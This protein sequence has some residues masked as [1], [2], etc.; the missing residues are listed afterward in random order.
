MKTT[1]N[2]QD[3]WYFASSAGCTEAEEDPGFD[4]TEA[5]EAFAFERIEAEE[6]F[7]T[8]CADDPEGF[9]P[10]HG[11][12]FFELLFSSRPEA[13][14]L[15]NA[16]N[17]SDYTDPDALCIR[18]LEDALFLWMKGD[19]SFVV[20]LTLSLF[21]RQSI[22]E[23]GLPD[24]LFWNLYELMPENDAELIPVPAY[25]LFYNGVEK[26]Y[27]W[28]VNTG[29]CEYNGGPECRIPSM[30]VYILDITSGN[31]EDLLDACRPLREYR[32]IAERFRSRAAGGLAI[33]VETAER[34]VEECIRDGILVDFLTQ[35]RET[36]PAVAQ[37]D[38]NNASRQ[39]FSGK[40]EQLYEDAHFLFDLMEKIKCI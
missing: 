27:D 30:S 4:C 20:R 13:L 11:E 37:H 33:A 26:K 1:Q 32:M 36:A 40:L 12:N 16:L 8:G 9:A 23:D 18:P 3:T 19:H 22:D 28:P 35:H 34:V 17:H 29:S 14:S 24:L 21:S 39:Y 5:E 10:G 31:N 6:G 7:V 25:I 15:Y 2:T 38:F